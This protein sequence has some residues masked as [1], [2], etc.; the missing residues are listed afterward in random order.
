MSHF[1]NRFWFWMGAPSVYTWLPLPVFFCL[2]ALVVGYQG[3]RMQCCYTC[4]AWDHTGTSSV[5]W[6]F[7]SLVRWSPC[8]AGIK[9]GQT[10][11][12]LD[13]YS[14]FVLFPQPLLQA[15]LSTVT[16]GENPSKYNSPGLIP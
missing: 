14:L 15:S 5:S 4:G 2:Q 9:P 12:S 8:D 16:M 6:C 1:C 13:V 3:L 11:A 10:H 7:Q